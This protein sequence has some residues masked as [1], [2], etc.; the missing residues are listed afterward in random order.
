MCVVN[1]PVGCS[2]KIVNGSRGKV[3]G[4]DEVTDLPIVEFEMG[5]T[6]VMQKHRWE[7]KE[8]MSPK[9][10]LIRIEQIP[11]ILAWAITIHKSQGSTLESVIVDAGDCWADGQLYVAF[12]RV[13]TLEGLKLINFSPKSVKTNQK[14][15]DFY[16][17]ISGTKR[18]PIL[19]DEEK[20]E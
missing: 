17:S 3:V 4:F 19:I 8:S 14:V 13:K 18:S 11:L 12:S 20:R 15:L 16:K 6:F 2:L 5:E 1:G 9:S 10:G 7:I